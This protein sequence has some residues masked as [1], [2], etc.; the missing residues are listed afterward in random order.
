[1]RGL[2]GFELSQRI[3]GD[4]GIAEPWSD[5]VHN[6]LVNE[7]ERLALRLLLRAEPVLNSYCLRLTGDIPVE[8]DSLAS[9]DTALE[10]GG[11]A[12]YSHAVLNRDT[13]DWPT[14]GEE[15]GD[16]T[17]TSKLVSF[18]ATNTWPTVRKAFLATSSDSTGLLVDSTTLPQPRGLASG[19]TLQF[20]VKAKLS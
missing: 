10:P 11:L 12:G 2:L 20:R 3:V 19:E 1:M 15:A 6:D 8:T 17:L 18:A 14:L 16:A 9:L 5:W 4:D 13:T 7:G